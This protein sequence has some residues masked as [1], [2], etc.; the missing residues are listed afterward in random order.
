MSEDLLKSRQGGAFSSLPKSLVTG[1]SQ[2]DELPSLFSLK[3]FK[4]QLSAQNSA[5]LKANSPGFLSAEKGYHGKT[6]S[7]LQVTWNPRFREPFHGESLSGDFFPLEIEALEKRLKAARFQLVLPKLNFKGEVELEYRN[8]NRIAG[9][10]LEPIQGEGGIRPLCRE[11]LQKVSSLCNAYKVPLILDEI[12]SGSFRTGRFLASSNSGIEADYYLLGKA[13]GGGMVKVAALLIEKS[14]YREDFGL[15]H[16]STYAEDGLSSQVAEGAIGL[17]A[18]RARDIQKTGD[19]LKARLNQLQDRFSEVVQEVRGEGLMLGIEF[20]DYTL[21]ANVGLQLLART[22]YLSY[23]YAGFLLNKWGIRVGAPLS[24]PNTLRIQPAVCIDESDMDK[25]IEGLKDL[26]RILKL[27]D[28]YKLIEY[29]LPSPYK[30]LRKFPEDFRQGEIELPDSSKSTS[31][32]GFISHFIH[33]GTVQEAVPALAILDRECID[34]LLKRI[35][36]IGEAILLGSQTI[37]SKTGKTVELLLIRFVCHLCHLQGG[38]E[39]ETR[40]RS[41]RNSAIGGWNY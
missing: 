24:H 9:V 13:L 6:L 5:L 31:T 23:V 36:P 22:G 3:S 41:C 17:L 1:R 39:A 30:G 29:T 12:Q 2:R 25:L 20:R 37:K 38:D 10:L 18:K 14:I 27:Q 26:C 33:E 4:N 11:F 15:L 32:V 7:A 16:S 19:Q 8:F 28:L 40:W 21:S 35:L 34:Y